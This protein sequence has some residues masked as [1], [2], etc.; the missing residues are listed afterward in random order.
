MNFLGG[1]TSL[2]L[3]LKA[4]ERSKTKELKPFFRRN[5]STVHE[6]LI[7]VNFPLMTHFSANFET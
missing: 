5:V 3:F 2:G 7:T 6:R 1:A 4:H